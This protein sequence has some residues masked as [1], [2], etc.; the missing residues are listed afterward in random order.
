MAT[1]EH[2][3]ETLEHF[4]QQKLVKLEELRTLEIMIRHL[5]Q[6]VGEQP[7]A[8]TEAS[9]A[10]FLPFAI[11]EQK[12]AGGQS[13]GNNYKPRNDEFFSLSIADAAKAFLEKIGHAMPVDDILRV[14]TTGG[15]KVGGADPKRTLSITLGQGKREFILTGPSTYGLRK[16]YPNI[17]KLGRPEAA[18]PIK[19]AAPKRGAKKPTPKRHAPRG[20]LGAT[21]VKPK[22]T[23][24]PAGVSA[25]VAEALSDNQLKSA[26]EVLAAVERKVGHQVKKIAVYGTLRKKEFEQ[27]GDKYRTRL[28]GEEP[29]VVQ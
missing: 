17:P 3:R 10:P 6:Q 18:S 11:P 5:Q 15:C 8:T 9:L 20:K 29:Q 2:L 1:P 13:A 28:P 16:F 21:P 12:P 7:D 19:K 14:I 26:D 24:D 27:I 25:A 22:P 4:K 23:H